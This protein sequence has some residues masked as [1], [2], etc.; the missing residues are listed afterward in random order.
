MKVLILPEESYRYLQHVFASHTQAGFAPDEVLPAA[1]LFA[2]IQ[3]AQTVD[4]SKLGNAEITKLGPD[5][6]SLELKPES[7]LDPPGDHNGAV[8]ND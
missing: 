1:D 7:N 2:R 6:A 5:G 8:L 4:F 3:K